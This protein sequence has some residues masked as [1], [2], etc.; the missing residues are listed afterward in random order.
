MLQ[1][2][3]IERLSN[4][5]R[6]ALTN[7][8]FNTFTMS[9]LPSLDNLYQNI[10]QIIEQAQEDAYQSINVVM[11][12]T[13]W[14]IGKLIAEAEQKNDKDKENFTNTLIPSLSI[15]LS[16]KLGKGFSETNLRDM[17]QFYIV[18]PK[19][20][21]LHHQLTWTHYRLLMRIEDE[22]ARIFYIKEAVK[23]HWNVKQLNRQV[24]SMYFERLLISKDRK[25]LLESA[26]IE[27]SELT[28]KDFF[29]D[30][31][32]MEFLEI[33]RNA[34][35]SEKDLETAITDKIQDF[36]LELGRGFSFVSRQQHIKTETKDFFIDL[37]FYNYILKCFVLIDLKIGE[38]SHQD[39]GQ[40]DMYVR[41]YEDKMRQESD[42]PTIGIILCNRK[43]DTVVKYSMLKD[44]EHLFASK[45]QLYIPSKEELA[46][47]MER[48]IEQYD[49]RKRLK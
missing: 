36:L 1:T 26:Q 40:M 34:N 11:L 49:I 35:Y 25:M 28:F 45:Y 5:I 12:Q 10:Y 7:T 42:N 15:K 30:P 29:K 39:I 38:L 22:S 16:E 6:K 47:E 9:D 8:T 32:V 48:E 23:G 19:L 46:Q 27:D 3:D 18:F 43:D 20:E 17:R 44:S 41:L 37:V 33:D 24:N 14:S 31:H 13:Y 21:D 4:Q 2:N